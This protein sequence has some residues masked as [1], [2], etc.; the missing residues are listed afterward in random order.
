MKRFIASLIPIDLSVYST[1][2]KCVAAVGMS[3]VAAFWLGWMCTPKQAPVNP[4]KAAEDDAIE[5]VWQRVE[6]TIANDGESVK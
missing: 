2:A 5:D 1:T 6:R 4:F 3:I